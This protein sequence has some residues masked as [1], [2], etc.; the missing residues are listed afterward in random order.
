MS[1]PQTLDFQCALVTGGAG[2]LGRA[3]AQWL[4][5]EGG[6]KVI[7]AGRTESK[8][9]EAAKELNVPYYVLDTGDIKSIKPFAEKL[10]KE[11]PEVDCLINNAGVVSNDVLQ[12]YIRGCS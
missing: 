4:V 9:K 11:H 10:I 6:K 8:L 5:N 2:G 3:M 1:K 7:I 12:A